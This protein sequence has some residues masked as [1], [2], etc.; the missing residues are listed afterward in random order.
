MVV[1]RDRVGYD[2]GNSDR[3]VDC[4]DDTRGKECGDVG[5]SAPA[6]WGAAA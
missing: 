2:G 6:G 3:G 5:G 4:V 1:A